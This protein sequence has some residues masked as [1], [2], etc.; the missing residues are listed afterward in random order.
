VTI[1]NMA[2]INMCSYISLIKLL[3][4]GRLS[5]QDRDLQKVQLELFELRRGGCFFK[6]EKS[7]LNLKSM[8]LLGYI[9]F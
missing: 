8:P 1:V 4:S 5:Q 9:K 7:P 2:A 3:K 6:S